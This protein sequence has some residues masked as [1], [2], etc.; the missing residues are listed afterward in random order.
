MIQKLF[1]LFLLIMVLMAN[2]NLAVVLA[3]EP[4]GRAEFSFSGEREYQA[5]RLVP[6]I[7]N[8]SNRDLSDLSVQDEHGNILPF[9]INSYE[10]VA[11][12]ILSETTPLI[13]THNFVRDGASYFDYRAE[14]IDYNHDTLATSLIVQTNSDMFAKSIDLWGSHDGAEW[15]FIQRDSLYRVDDTEKL[16]IS[17]STTKRFTHYRIRIPN[18]GNND[19]IISSA[20]LEY[21]RHN[22]EQNFFTESFSPSFD[23]AQEGQNTL[24]TLH[25]LKNVSINEVTVHTDSHFRRRVS[26]ANRQTQELY[27]LSFAS[28]GQYQNLTLSFGGY[29]ESGDTVVIVIHNGDDTPINVENITMTYFTD[30]VVFRTGLGTVGVMTFGNPAIRVAP[31]YDIV[32]YKALILDEGYDILQ[33][34][35]IKISESLEEPAPQD[36]TLIF[37]IVVVVVSIL[38]GFVVLR[39]LKVRRIDS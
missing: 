5:V 21:S 14:Q 34:N 27:N 18:D 11:A 22:V 37:N 36:Y 1:V 30:E 6:E 20:Y 28:G 25:G 26:F 10:T 15:V 38:L 33:F 16:N 17:F 24:I 39:Q 7:Y 9:F 8:H 13:P 2:F 12:H 32:N 31:T 29:A 3:A 23:V 19:L 4:A 35:S